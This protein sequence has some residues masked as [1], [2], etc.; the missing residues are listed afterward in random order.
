MNGRPPFNVFAKH[1]SVGRARFQNVFLPFEA[2]LDAMKL[3]GILELRRKL[4]EF[5]KQA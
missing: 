3:N 2:S 4:L 5:Y 1:E